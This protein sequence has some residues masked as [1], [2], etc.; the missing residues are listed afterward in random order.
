MSQVLGLDMNIVHNCFKTVS[1]KLLNDHLNAP[2][3][4]ERFDVA[5]Y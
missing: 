2:S 3:M 5:K 4:E 1:M